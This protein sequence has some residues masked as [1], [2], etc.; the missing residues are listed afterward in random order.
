[1]IVDKGPNDFFHIP[2][3]GGQGPR[4]AGF[5]AY[6]Q[7]P[8]N[9]LLSTNSLPSTSTSGGWTSVLTSVLGAAG[10]IL[11][12]V[13]APKPTTVILPSAPVPGVNAP[14][15]MDW[16]KIAIYGGG[17]MFGLIVLSMVLRD[18]RR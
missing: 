3:R 5:G 16:Q 7:V 17:A 15:A 18:S 10:S 6:G 8:I 13:L 4:L 11:P 2:V 1:L 14:A 12:G 9:T